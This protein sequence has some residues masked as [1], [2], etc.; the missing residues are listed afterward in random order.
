MTDKQ[1]TIEKQNKDEEEED[2]TREIPEMSQR[3]KM[4]LKMTEKIK[5]S[6]HLFQTTKRPKIL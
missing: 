4:L 3:L 1:Y 2:R 6:K 5:F